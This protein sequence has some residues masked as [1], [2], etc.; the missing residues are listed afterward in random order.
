M[1][2]E[3]GRIVLIYLYVDDSIIIGDSIALIK[4]IKQPMSQLFE[5][6]DLGELRYCLGLEIWRDLGQ[7]FCPRVSMLEVYWKD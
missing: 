4:E 6:N 7:N 5:M 1:K 2:D 3:Q